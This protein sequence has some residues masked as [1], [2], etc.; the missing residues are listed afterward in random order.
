V[1]P[2][3]CVAAVLWVLGV[4]VVARVTLGVVTR[5]GLDAMEVLLWLGLAEEPV[6]QRRAER[7]RLRDLFAE[8]SATAAP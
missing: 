6:G 1:L 3:L 2:A 4:W 5:L 8:P 7:E